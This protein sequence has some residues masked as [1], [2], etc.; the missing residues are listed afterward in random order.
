MDAVDESKAISLATVSRRD[1]DVIFEGA[2]MGMVGCVW[3]VFTNEKEA[4]GWTPLF[5]LR[6]MRRT[7][8]PLRD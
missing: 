7:Q 1:K 2:F 3:A 4:S 8:G 6:S 5:F